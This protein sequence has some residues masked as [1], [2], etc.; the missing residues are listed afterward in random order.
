MKSPPQSQS[1]NHIPITKPSW[2]RQFMDRIHI[3][4]NW[5]QG[6]AQVMTL[7]GHNGSVTDLKFDEYR[8]VTSSD[9]GSII[10]WH[11]NNMKKWRPK[12]K[13][14]SKDKRYKFF[15]TKEE[16]K[17]DNNN[18]DDNDND[19]DEEEDKNY[20]NDEYS[21][22]SEMSSSVSDCNNINNINNNNKQQHIQH[23]TA[24]IIISINPILKLYILFIVSLSYVA[25]VP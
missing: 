13:L 20:D 10:L 14:N 11:L 9:D 7:M 23:I 5:R 4:R 2:K 17:N 22:D 16:K 18:D 3:E 1:I 21:D 6:T 24:A 19:N 25:S 15:P 8:L 12:H